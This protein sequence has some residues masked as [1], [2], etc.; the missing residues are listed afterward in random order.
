MPDHQLPALIIHDGRL[1]GGLGATVL[2]RLMSRSGQPL[3]EVRALNREQNAF[4]FW[5]EGVEHL[6][7]L[8]NVENTKL[9]LFDITYYDVDPNFCNDAL[10]R[11]DVRFGELEVWSNRWPGGYVHSNRHVKIPPDDIVYTDLGRYLNMDEKQLLRFALTAAETIP[12]A[13]LSDDVRRAG[14]LAMWI[15]TDPP[16]RWRQLLE[17]DK[18]GDVLAQSEE[19]EVAP[20]R[21]RE[22]T[23]HDDSLAEQGFIDIEITPQ[24]ARSELPVIDALCRER[25]VPPSAVI[26]AWLGRERVLLIR[27]DTS[28]SYPALRW[29][30][31]N[32]H[33]D[34]VP[35]AYRGRHYGP[36]DAVYYRIDSTTHERSQLRPQFRNLASRLAVTQSGGRYLPAGLARV[37]AQ[38]ANSVLQST[39]LTGAYTGAPPAI[40]V[41]AQDLYV[42]LHQSSRTGKWRQTL[43]IPIHVRDAGATAFLYRD[44]GYNLQKAERLMEG[45]LIGLAQ[46]Q[47]EWLGDTRQPVRLRIDVRHEMRESRREFTR[48]VQSALQQPRMSP[49]PADVRYVS[50]DSLIGRFLKMCDM[51]KLVCYDESETIGPSVAHA[52]TLLATARTVQ[53]GKAGARVLDLFSGSGV[54]NRLLSRFG[55]QVT[56]VDKYVSAASVEVN[57]EHG[58]GLWLRADARRVLD[59]KEP[60]IE[61]AFDVIGL[62]PP[63]AELLELL[64]GGSE[65]AS[66]VELCATRAN[67]MVMYQGHS[68]QLGRLR[69]V[70]EGLVAA[71]WVHVRILQVEEEIIVVAGTSAM[72]E[73]NDFYARVIASLKSIVEENKLGGL[74]IWTVFSPE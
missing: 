8:P 72:T 10:D 59:E 1:P 49:I 69:L 27:R 9:I 7:S 63:H 61:Q 42:L 15:E 25:N 2:G 51:H 43:T 12:T 64:F 56:S 24:A 57:A 16:T 20:S 70:Y 34:L 50:S 6:L 62:D 21:S 35:D 19:L 66:L 40:E 37:I 32:R 13:A 14:A 52:L 48:E 39:D 54:A 73:F 3:R 36:Q 4:S 23:V 45:A 33:A 28:F 71:G 5:T 30:I 11:L 74:D 41:A 60:I 53:G 58:D 55:H 67:T 17:T 31:E 38:I 18:L 68:T 44:N 46:R 47:L 26:L 65:R 29:Q 22:A